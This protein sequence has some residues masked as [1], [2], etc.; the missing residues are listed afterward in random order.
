MSNQGFEGDGGF[1]SGN[2]DN[3]GGAGYDMGGGNSFGQDA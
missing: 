1:Y 3:Q 2:Y